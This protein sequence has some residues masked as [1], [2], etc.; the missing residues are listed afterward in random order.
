MSCISRVTGDQGRKCDLLPKAEIAEAKGHS[1]LET[2][3]PRNRL[4]LVQGSKV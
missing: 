1:L 3:Y 2:L 4:Y